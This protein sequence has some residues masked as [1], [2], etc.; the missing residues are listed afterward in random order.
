MPSGGTLA[1]ILS[2]LDYYSLRDVAN[3]GSPWVFSPVPGPR[4]EKPVSLGSRLFGVRSVPHLGVLTTFVAGSTDRALVQRSWGLLDGGNL[5]GRKF[6]YSEYVRVRNA[7][8]G[9]AVHFAIAFCMLALVLPPVRW[10]VKKLVF[11]PGEGASKEST[12]KDA[13]EFRAI[14]TADEDV[15]T[16]GRAIAKLRWDGGLYYLTGI[17]L[18]EAAMVI[19]RDDDIVTRIGGGLLTPAMLGEP[20]IER[21]RHAGLILETEMMS[22]E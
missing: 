21:L 10:L 15:P 18:A 8:Y 4:P 20:F 5:Y 9:I 13:I 22:D 1:T 2:I 11:A 16:P 14:A 19:L 6:Q 12:R 3:A 7:A 17:F